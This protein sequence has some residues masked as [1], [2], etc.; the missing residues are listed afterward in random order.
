M[1]TKW[2]GRRILNPRTGDY[3]PNFFLIITQ[4]FKANVKIVKS[5]KVVP[6]HAVKA[7]GWFGFITPFS[8]KLDGDKWSSSHSC[9]FTPWNEPW[10]ALK[11][12]LVG[13]Q[14]QFGRLGE[15]KNL[16]DIG[17]EKG[18]EVPGREILKTSRTG[19]SRHWRR[20]RKVNIFLLS[21]FERRTFQPLHTK[22]VG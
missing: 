10:Y 22:T 11:W 1:P 16:L 3:L 6:V 12:R 4:T 13:S 17:D 18:V 9:R 7:C 21:G 2:N 19:L 8:L 14:S 20:R 5:G 15:V